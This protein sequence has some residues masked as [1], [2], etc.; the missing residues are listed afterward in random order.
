LEVKA[1]I[2]DWRGSIYDIN[3]RR[4]DIHLFL[5][6]TGFY[7]RTEMREPDFCRT[8]TGR[9]SLEE[10]DQVLRLESDMP[11]PSEWDRLSGKWTIKTVSDCESSNCLLVLRALILAS[12]NLP[13]LFYRVH[14]DGRAYG[15]N[16]ENNLPIQK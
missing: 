14:G 1:V 8:D 4:C 16:W 13:I 15:T 12:R 10:S 9:W 5:D 11:D 6:H 3:G 2:G 7:E